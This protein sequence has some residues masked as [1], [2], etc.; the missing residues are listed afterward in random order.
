[1][2]VLGC[3]ADCNSWLSIDRN[4]ISFLFVKPKPMD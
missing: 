2:F 3:L 1:M 4:A